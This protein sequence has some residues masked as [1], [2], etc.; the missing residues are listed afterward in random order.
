MRPESASRK[1]SGETVSESDVKCGNSPSARCT[2][3]T[4]PETRKFFMRMAKTGSR[5]AG[6][7]SWKKVR[8][9]ST[10]ETTAS[11]AISSPSASTTPETAR[12]LVRICCTSALVRISAPA[13]LAA[14]P[15]AR[16]NSPSP[17]RGNAAEPTG[18]GSAAARSSRSAVETAD[19]LRRS[20]EAR[21]W[22]NNLEIEILELKVASDVG[23][24]GPKR[25]RERGS[26][27]ARMKFLGNGAAAEVFPA[28][29]NGGLEAALGK[30]ESGNERIVT[31]ADE[32]NFLSEGH[33][34]LAAFFQFFRMTWLAMRPFAPMMPPPGCVAEPH[35]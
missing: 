7:R 8:F 28:F 18:C 23:A 2:L 10:P 11:Q 19:V 12:A 30:I 31:A 25:V 3:A 35:I 17:P 16:E 29:E 33:G 34:Q 5:F 13:A 20:E 9:G 22:L 15:S 21:F 32:N 14:S 1:L 27:K 4:L 26:A 24:K 6:S